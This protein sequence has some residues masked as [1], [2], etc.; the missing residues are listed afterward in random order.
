MLLG[1]EAHRVRKVGEISEEENNEG[2]KEYESA[3]ST[4]LHGNA[5]NI[6]KKRG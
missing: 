2:P 5:V 4:G 1:E 6:F 3:K